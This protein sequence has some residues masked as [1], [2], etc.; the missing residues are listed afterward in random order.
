MN[1]LRTTCRTPKTK[2]K[3]FLKAL[4]RGEPPLEPLRSIDISMRGVTA[5][6]PKGFLHIS[7]ERKI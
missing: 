7:S 4:R 1:V 6:N 2:S 5:E 3:L